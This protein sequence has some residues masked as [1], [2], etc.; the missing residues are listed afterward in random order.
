MARKKLRTHYDNLKVARDAPPEVI[1]AAYR[2]LSQRHHPDKNP[3]NERAAKVMVIVNASYAVLSDPA[4][5]KAHDE[6]IASQE[7]NDHSHFDSPEES[8]PIRADPRRVDVRTVDTNVFNWVWER[9]GKYALALAV[10][11]LIVAMIKLPSAIS[12]ASKANAISSSAPQQQS[13]I[14]MV[15]TE[16]QFRSALCALTEMPTD[17]RAKLRTAASM[18]LQRQDEVALSTSF[19]IDEVPYH[20][21]QCFQKHAVITFSMRKAKQ[22]FRHFYDQSERAMRLILMVDATMSKGSEERT[23]ELG[24]NARAE[25]Q[26]RNERYY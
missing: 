9:I 7:I 26:R 14:A 19:E 2:A 11:L 6:W 12:K 17:T 25:I 5:R 22:D 3:G 1:K 21:S 18:Y 8:A 15:A 13:S 24:R 23:K 20:L 10:P 16:E 4:A